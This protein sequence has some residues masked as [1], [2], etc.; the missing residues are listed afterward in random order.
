MAGI[1]RRVQLALMAAGELGLTQTTLYG[2]YQLGLRSG[3]WQRLTPIH[4]RFPRANF[5]E[6]WTQSDDPARAE[7]QRVYRDFMARYPQASEA[8][9]AEAKEIVTGKV[10]LFGGPPVRL[11]LAPPAPL[12]H[13]SAYE[14][15]APHTAGDPDIKMIWEPAR[16]GWVYPLARAFMLTGEN[17]YAQCFWRTL[18]H[19]LEKNPANQGPNWV[20]AQEV[21]IRIIALVFGMRV[22]AGTLPADSKLHRALPLVIAAHAERIPPTMLYARAQHNNHLLTEAAGLITAGL[23]LPDHP[24]ARRWRVMGWRWLV[25][26]LRDQIDTDGSY[27]QHATNYHRLMLQITLWANALD[28]TPDFGYAQPARQRLAAATHWLLNHCDFASGRAVNLGANDGA[29]LFPLADGGFADYRPLL[30]AASRAYLNTPAFPPGAWDEYSLWLDWLAGEPPSLK[31]TPLAACTPTPTR[32]QT[33]GSWASLR[34]VRYNSRPSHADQLHVDLWRSGFPVTLD[35]GTFRY[36]APPPWNN[37]LARTTVHNTISVDHRD[38]MTRA[39]RFLWLNWAQAS[40]IS[41]NPDRW[42]EA[43]HNGYANIGVIHRRR[44]ELLSNNLWCVT[45]Q[46]LPVKIQPR[47]H[48]FWLHWLLADGDWQL[49]DNILLLSTPASRVRVKIDCQDAAASQTI[50]L[51]RAGVCLQGVDPQNPTLGW[52]SPTYNYKEPALSLCAVFTAAPPLLITTEFT[53]LD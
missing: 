53:F 13:W 36:T 50:S 41:T 38:Q 6:A 27:A 26:G 37:T 20:S 19:F 30:Q 25:R 17:G 14:L 29:Y 11:Q 33:T 9:I 42:I 28:S 45:D 12:L 1:F 47:S 48:A 7:F 5:E 10:R 22:F 49:N 43:E 16:L 2:L 40:I 21:A 35:A 8:V 32:I 52:Y 18:A 46:L 44:L 51:V 4:P 39:G 15:G 24:A 23:A 3:L 31:S 34:A